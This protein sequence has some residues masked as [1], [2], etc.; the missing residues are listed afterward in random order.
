MEKQDGRCQAV[1]IFC[2]YFINLFT[3][4]YLTFKP[5]ESFLFFL[6]HM[7][8]FTALKSAHEQ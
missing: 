2:E 6:M 8:V 1:L 4:I 3:L 7:F 5:L